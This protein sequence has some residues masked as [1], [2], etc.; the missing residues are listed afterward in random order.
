MPL[1]FLT[2]AYPFQL[3]SKPLMTHAME[4][5]FAEDKRSVCLRKPEKYSYG[6]VAQPPQTCVTCKQCKVRLAAKQHREGGAA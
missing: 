6:W 3:R 4:E 1:A 5:P 2:V